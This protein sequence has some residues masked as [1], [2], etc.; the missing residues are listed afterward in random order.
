MKPL[1][2]QQ[3]LNFD[4][5]LYLLFP[6]QDEHGGSQNGRPQSVFVPLGRLG[7]IGSGDEFP[8]GFVLFSLSSQSLLE[9]NSMP[10]VVASIVAAKSSA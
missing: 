7:D 2:C 1:F 10:S 5:I 8:T 6:F 3:K 9:S 4:L